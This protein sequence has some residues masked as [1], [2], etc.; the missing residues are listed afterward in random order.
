MQKD[1]VA[2]IRQQASFCSSLK[3]ARSKTELLPLTASTA[4]VLLT[5]ALQ[6]KLGCD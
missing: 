6:P 2:F 1:G 4:L 3:N 5:A